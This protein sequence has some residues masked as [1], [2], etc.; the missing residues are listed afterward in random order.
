MVP[1]NGMYTHCTR[2]SWFLAS[3]LTGASSS[4]QVAVLSMCA[5]GAAATVEALRSGL[6][7]A[8]SIGCRT[9]AALVLAAKVTDEV[10][11]WRIF[12]DPTEDRHFLVSLSEHLQI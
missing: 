6:L 12:R 8:F 4:R 3:N 7:F 2:S 9:E 5:E 11:F 10:R 1:M